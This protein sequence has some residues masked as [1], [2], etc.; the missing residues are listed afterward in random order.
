MY[1]EK[2]YAF[3]WEVTRKSSRRNEK[4]RMGMQNKNNDKLYL[5]IMKLFQIYTIKVMHRYSKGMYPFSPKID[6]SVFAQTR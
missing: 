4:N 2:I 1:F 3:L 5:I 6:L